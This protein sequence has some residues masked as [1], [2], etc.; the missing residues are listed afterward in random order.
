MVLIMFIIIYEDIISDKRTFYCANDNV[1]GYN[2]IHLNALYD[3]LN[4]RF[5]D[6]VLQDRRDENENRALI[7]MLENINR[8]TIIAA[9]RSYDSY[10]NIAHLEEKGLK[11]VI[12]V[13]SEHGIVDKFNLPFDKLSMGFPNLIK[14]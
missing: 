14:N 8:A 1:K 11:Y 2:L 4:R 6:A 9:D 12:R 13:R 3:L 10:N 5:I 7:N